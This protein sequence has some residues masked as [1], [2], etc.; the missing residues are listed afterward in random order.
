MISE[1]IVAAIMIV[2]S[3]CGF[4]T[5]WAIV[6]LMIKVTK[7]QKP[8]AI[9][10]VGL[11]IADGVFSTLYLFYATPMVFFQNEFLD[12]W[13]HLCG[14][15]LMI[16]YDASTYFHFIISLNRFL[17]VFTPV[18]YHKMFSITF[19]KLIVMA[20][21]LLSFILITLFFQI[22]GCQNYYNAEYRAFQYSGGAICSLYG[23]YG[24]FYQVFTLTI[25]STLL[26]FTA[27]GKVVKMRSKSDKNSKELS[28]LKQSLSQTLFVLVIVCCFT[29]GPRLIPEKQFTFIFSSI[30]WSSVHCFDGI[31]TLIFNSEIR[32]KIS[33]TRP[34]VMVV[35]AVRSKATTINSLR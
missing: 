2:F 30:L 35:S 29:W 17:A 27:I 10:T 15:F 6:I 32:R 28:L 19:T 1:K 12:Y 11:A 3:S 22:L 21:Y 23:T 24:D 34:T 7:L 18:L 16:C 25:T 5:N 14:Y 9:L 8:F 4:F 31:F 13:S 20:T 33:S 26:D